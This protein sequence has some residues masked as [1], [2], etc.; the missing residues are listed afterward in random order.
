MENKTQKAYSEIFALIKKHKDVCIIFDVDDLERKSK[1]HLFGLELKE[2][3]GLNVD[4]KNINST[5][6]QRFGDYKT[7]GAWGEKHRRT[8][9]W[10][11]DGRQPDNE[12]LLQISFS[13]GAYIFGDGDYFNKDYPTDFFQKFWLELKS[14]NPDYI[15]EVNH[16]LYWKIENAKDIF[17]LFDDILNKYYALNNED[18]KQRRIKKMEADLAQ[19]KNT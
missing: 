12:L 16:G 19:L 4:P 9:S 1:V 3:Y 17:N 2:K 6:W 10:S 5:D 15:D 18:I 8:I 13:T 14:Y 7:I 11:I